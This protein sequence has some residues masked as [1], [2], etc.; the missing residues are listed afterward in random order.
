M[1][2]QIIPGSVVPPAGKPLLRRFRREAPR[3]PSVE[4]LRLSDLRQAIRENR[5]S[6]PAQVPVFAKHDRPDL[7]RRLVQLYF[8]LGW[9]CTDIAERHGITRQRVQQILNTWKRRAAQMGYV[10]DIP[11][12]P[13]LRKL[14]TLQ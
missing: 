3:V 8:L 1:A 9:S 6:F 4:A 13:Q 5:V 14:R 12:I 11:P 2:T 10:Q 7:Q